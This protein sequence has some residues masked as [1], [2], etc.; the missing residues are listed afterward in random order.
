[1]RRNYSLLNALHP[2]PINVSGAAPADCPNFSKS[3]SEI[4]DRLKSI[5]SLRP[6]VIED[7][8]AI[9]DK[10]PCLAAIHSYVETFVS[11]FDFFLLRNPLL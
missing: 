2:Q 8:I 1:M 7:V 3:Y 6:K 4:F 11:K 9:H 10:Y 5:N